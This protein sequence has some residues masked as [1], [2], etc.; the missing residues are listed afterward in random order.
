MI[1]IVVATVL[2]YG[3]LMPLVARLLLGEKEQKHQGKK[4]RIN[5][6]RQFNQT[7]ACEVANAFNYSA[8][9]PQAALN[10]TTNQPISP[11]AISEGSVDLSELSDSR[12][13]AGK[14]SRKS[15]SEISEFVHENEIK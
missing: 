8:D 11:N 2:I 14:E 15:A 4:I 12:K 1:L 10:N 6:G 9:R 7:P 5:S 3:S 13:S